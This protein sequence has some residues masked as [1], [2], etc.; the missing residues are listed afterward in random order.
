MRLRYALLA[1][2]MPALAH[3]QEIPSFALAQQQAYDIYVDIDGI[4]G[5][6]VTKEHAGWIDVL[7]YSHA[8]TNPGGVISGGGGGGA[9]KPVHEPVAFAKFLDSSSPALMDALNRGK[10]IADATFEFVQAGERPFV[11]FRVKLENVFVT[12][13]SISG[14]SGSDRPVEALALMYRKIT[15]TY[16]P[17]NAN[18]S[19]GTPISVSYDVSTNVASAVTLSSFE[20]FTEDD[21]VVFTWRTSREA[22]TYGFEV[23]QWGAGAF[24]RAAYVPGA[25]WSDKLL[26]YEVRIRGLDRGIHVFRLAVLGVDG[27]VAY[28]SEVEVALGVPGGQEVVVETPF[29]NPFTHRATVGVAV[30][31]PVEGRITLHDL[32]GREVGVVFEGMLEPGATQHFAV[33]AAPALAAGLY[34][35]RVETPDA[36]QTRLI[37][38]V[39]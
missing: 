16:I 15:W 2:L 37:T 14:A 19:A 25:G 10:A 24:Q 38:L 12:S 28:S 34:A 30:A 20:A 29:P 7:S 21:A 27:S 17:Q 6:V 13:Y 11:F 4:P 8:L 26:E 3:A 31:S 39:R 32:L 36:V 33:E 9:S 22:S 18:G 23:Q 5:E 1:L 35:L